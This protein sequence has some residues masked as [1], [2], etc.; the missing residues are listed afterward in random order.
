MVRLIKRCR[1][2]AVS[3]YLVHYFRS[4]SQAQRGAQV[5]SS[6]LTTNFSRAR[7]KAEIDWGDGTPAT[8]HEQ[9]S[10]SERLY[11]AQG[12]DTK[13][14]LGHKSQKQIDRYHDDRGKDWITVAV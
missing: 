3:P 1:D 10:L 14:L 7:D 5:T 12:I 9:R 4:T 13:S 2:Y 6:T 11:K 8:F